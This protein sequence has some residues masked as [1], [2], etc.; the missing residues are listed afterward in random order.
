M[1]TIF[2]VWNPAKNEGF[3]TDDQE[4]ANYC[5]TGDD[6]ACFGHSSVAEAFRE[7][8]ADE[9]DEEFEMQTLEIDG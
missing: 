1:K 5:S 7:S 3:V 4:D 8:Y 9:G 6:S 2:I